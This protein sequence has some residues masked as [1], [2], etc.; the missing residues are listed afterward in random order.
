MTQPAQ[1]P[2]RSGLFKRV[3]ALGNM[4]VGTMTKCFKRSDSWSWKSISAFIAFVG[5]LIGVIAGGAGLIQGIQR[6]RQLR[7]DVKIDLEV[8][9]RFAK[10]M[11]LD[12]AI[13]YYEKALTLDKGNID[14]HRRIIT[15]MRQ[16]IEQE[17]ENP[18]EIEDVLSR[19]Y[20]LQALHS[21][22]KTDIPLLL[23]E[24]KLLRYDEKFPHARA[25]LEEAYKLAP[26]DAEVLAQLGFVK[27]I[28]S[29]KDRV[30]GIDLLL[31]AIGS[32]PNEPRYHS[33]LAQVYEHVEEDAKSIRE[34]YQV[35][36][37]T[38]HATG[39]SRL[40]NRAISALDDLFAK[41]FHAEG[42]VT[43]RLK[44]PLEECAPIYE[45]VINEYEKLPSR[46]D[47][48]EHSR[49]GYMAALYYALKDFKK[50][51]HE[52]HK[53]FTKWNISYDQQ[54]NV[55]Q[56]AIPWMEL[57]VKILEEG[58]FDAN[59]LS[60]ARKALQFVHDKAKTKMQ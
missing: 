6:A 60:E 1:T 26:N 53:T 17:Q 31:R 9:D 7:T 14:A 30:E 22:L 57:H 8:G 12:K 55:S 38:D 42:A 3:V 41:F 56:D 24:A 39:S 29:P 46:F 33:F 13:E 25:V 45:Y 52:I 34:Y 4:V 50:A 48:L 15:A 16:K 2:R 10:E 43:P 20:Q 27:G 49:T 28:T 40:H 32:Q 51:D 59:T 21:H 37:L 36:K 44:I 18:P 35:A 54:K 11:R 47:S 5:V 58:R 23:E 19:I